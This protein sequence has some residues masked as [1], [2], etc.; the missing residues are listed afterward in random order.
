MDELVEARAELAR[1]EQEE[2]QL[3]KHLL[4]VRTAVGAQR[5]KIDALVRERGR[6]IAYLPTELLVW[7]LSLCI[8]PDD[9]SLSV[10]DDVYVQRRQLASVS[11]RWKDVIL[12]GP[13]LWKY[14]EVS[15]HEYPSLKTRLKRSCGTPLDIL[16][17]GWLIPYF[18]EQLAP[19]LEIIIP[20]ASRWNNLTINGNFPSSTALVVNATKHMEFPCLRRVDVDEF[21]ATSSGDILCPDILLPTSSPT[22]EHLMLR[23]F[24][25]GHGFSTLSN[26]LKTLDLTIRADMTALVLSP[27]RFFIQSLT[28]LSLVGNNNGWSLTRDSIQFPVLQ[29]LKLHVSD[30]RQFME[31][32]IAPMLRHLNYSSKLVENPASAAFRARLETDSALS[33]TFLSLL[34]ISYP[35]ILVAQLSSRHFPVFVVRRYMQMM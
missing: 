35:M 20:C 30:P 28:M 14:I 25:T 12:R 10:L 9:I 29:T 11:R 8:D 19:H 31:A 33:A 4:D 24:I 6:T 27:A 2:Q 32:I 1:L 16:I 21:G 5:T 22:I 7:I 15:P 26:K 13:I 34:V 3:L 18:P 17:S 23:N